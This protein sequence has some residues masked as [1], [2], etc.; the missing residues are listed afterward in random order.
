MRDDAASDDACSV[1]DRRSPA[2]NART[3]WRWRSLRFRSFWNR[4]R[5]PV[6]F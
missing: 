4:A 2:T 6:R 3:R 1:V 5:S